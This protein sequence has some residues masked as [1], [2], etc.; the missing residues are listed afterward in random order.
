MEKKESNFEVEVIFRFSQIF[1]KKYFYLFFIS[2]STNKTLNINF[3][4]I[5]E[6]LDQYF[7]RSE[8]FLHTIS[9]QISIIY[10]V[11]KLISKYFSPS[12]PFISF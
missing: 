9:P 4:D 11:V 8:L 12:I 3:I 5:K 2:F 1:K 6:T 10:G 7:N